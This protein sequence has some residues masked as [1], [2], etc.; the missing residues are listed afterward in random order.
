MNQEIVIE[1]KLRKAFYLQLEDESKKVLDFLNMWAKNINAGKLGKGTEKMSTQKFTS[2][3]LFKNVILPSFLIV[4]RIGSN[5]S[6]PLRCWRKYLSP[7]L[8]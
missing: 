3:V 4:A 1:E 5:L 6:F 8:S 7:I 2:I